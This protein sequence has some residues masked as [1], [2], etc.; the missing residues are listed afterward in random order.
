MGDQEQEQEQH[1]IEA[2]QHFRKSDTFLKWF[3]G[4]VIPLLIAALG[5]LWNVTTSVGAHVGD[6]RVLKQKV[7][8]VEESAKRTADN[9]SA[10]RQSVNDFKA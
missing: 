5:L 9:A 10:I 1:R 6:F 3:A 4:I 7:E 2:R 8:T